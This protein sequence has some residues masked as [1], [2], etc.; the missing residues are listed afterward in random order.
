MNGYIINKTSGW[1]HALKRNIGPGQKIDLDELFEQ[2]GEKH[3]I[4]EGTPFVEWLR[5]IKLS[6]AGV[7][8]I[9]H[10]TEEGK[11]QKSAKT[12]I[13][14]KKEGKPKV[15]AEEAM[16]I[17]AKGLDV[18]E[19]ADLS[20]RKARETLPKFTDLKTLKYAL[21]QANQLADKN[22]LCRMLRKRI[23]ELE[24]SNR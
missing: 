1:R 11:P 2:Y 12:E 3:E 8:G 16:P 23:S 10:N 15:E 19:V 9:I 17:V 4:Q 6:D 14:K 7:W 18:N 5:S 24:L 21:N 13:P 22:I 20:V